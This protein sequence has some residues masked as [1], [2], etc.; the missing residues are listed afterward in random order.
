MGC[1]E[2]SQ[3]EGDERASERER[4]TCA[5]VRLEIREAICCLVASLD[6]KMYKFALACM[7]SAVCLLAM[8][9]DQAKIEHDSS[10][11]VKHRIAHR[12]TLQKIERRDKER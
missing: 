10:T 12:N 11:Q 5:A 8:D 6:Y 2:E 7:V 9:R 4:L 3:H 1:L